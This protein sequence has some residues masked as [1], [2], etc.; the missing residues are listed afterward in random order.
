MC[1][2]LFAYVCVY[3]CVSTSTRLESMY[4]ALKIF[5][6]KANCHARNAQSSAQNLKNIFEKYTILYGE[7]MRGWF[8]QARK[9]DREDIFRA[10][11]T[12]FPV[13][14]VYV[15]VP[16]VNICVFMSVCVSVSQCFCVCVYV[17]VCLCVR[18]YFCLCVYIYVCLCVCLCLY[19][20]VFVC[21]CVCVCVY[22]CVFVFIPVRTYVVCV[23]VLMCQRTTEVVRQ[24]KA[25]A[26]PT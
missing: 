20:C 1:L 12:N 17:C 9:F 15:P 16:V 26:F 4:C 11:N 10:Q 6:A 3:S 13:W 21:V 2:R 8:F 19:L 5:L 14:Y 25:E 18:L 23:P 7:K 22:V 24:E